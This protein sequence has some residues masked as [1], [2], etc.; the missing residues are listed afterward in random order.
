[1]KKYFP[2]IIVS[3]LSFDIIL[4]LSRYHNQIFFTW[5]ESTNEFRQLFET[6]AHQ[7]KDIQIDFTMGD[8]IEFFNIHIENLD[9]TLYT[10]VHHD[11]SIPQHTLPY[12][13]DNAQ[14][15]H[16]HWFR[17]SLIQAVRYCTSVFDFNNERIYL[18]ITC[19]TNGYSVEFVE[20]RIHH[21]FKHFDALSLRSSL[22]QHVYQQLQHRL[23][24][25]SHEQQQFSRTNQELV[26]DNQLIHM[27]YFYQYGP[28]NEF[29]K[30]LRKILR[31]NIHLRTSSAFEKRHRK[32]EIILTT[33]PKYSFNALLSQ[34]KPDHMLLNKEN[35]NF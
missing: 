3:I 6:L 31:E 12:T 8:K 2:Q 18:E 4:L 15:A 11:T 10:R 7:T 16:S 24:N 14:D 34:Q 20:R 30:K 1:M 9:G 19:L 5:N 17:S 33:K 27:S 23:F 21:F 13:I 25:F 35:V 28:K 22:D 26:N 29:N 32:I